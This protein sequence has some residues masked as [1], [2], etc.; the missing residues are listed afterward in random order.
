MAKIIKQEFIP[1]DIFGKN[2]LSW[3][4]DLDVKIHLEFMGLE[5]TIA[6]DNDATTQDCAKVMIFLCHYLN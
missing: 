3:T 6:K 2:Y 5:K 4:M 1:L